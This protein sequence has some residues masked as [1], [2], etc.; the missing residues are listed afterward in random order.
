MRPPSRPGSCK[1]KGKPWPTFL[2]PAQPSSAQ[3]TL[4][5]FWHS[6]CVASRAPCL[7]FLVGYDENLTLWIVCRGAKG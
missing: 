4:D 6:G 5:E 3:W 1:P 7:P 2:F